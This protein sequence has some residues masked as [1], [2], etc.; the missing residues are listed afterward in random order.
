MLRR[1]E[2]DYFYAHLKMAD[3]YRESLRIILAR[4]NMSSHLRLRLRFRLRL[5]S[6]LGLRLGLELILIPILT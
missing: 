4:V 3:T 1:R 6:R 5:G 2:G